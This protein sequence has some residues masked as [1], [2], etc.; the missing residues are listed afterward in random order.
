MDR[1]SALLTAIL[2][3]SLIAAMVYAAETS[4]PSI[5]L[6]APANNST[7]IYNHTNF[8][9]I[10]TDDSKIVR[11]SL[12]INDSL[13]AIIPTIT[14]ATTNYFYNIIIPQNGTYFW[15]VSCEDNL[16]NT[17]TSGINNF[18]VS[19][20]KVPP[21]ITL[22]LSGTKINRSGAA[23]FLFWVNDYETG[24]ASCQLFLNGN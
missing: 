12:Y 4:G 23:E 8:S 11:C 24:V 3:L 18:V 9:Y 14:N 16:S 15:K 21:N 1:K 7:V 10:P 20:D 5:T 2:A 19:I 6:S 22:N 17:G 13:T